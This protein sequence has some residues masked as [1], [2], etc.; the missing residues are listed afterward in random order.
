MVYTTWQAPLVEGHVAVHSGTAPG[1]SPGLGGSRA[2]LSRMQ[3]RSASK[4]DADHVKNRMGYADPVGWEA[5]RQ[6]PRWLAGGEGGL[7][8]RCQIPACAR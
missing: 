7:P 1:R 6:A 2:N 3:Q 4:T 5:D 8:V